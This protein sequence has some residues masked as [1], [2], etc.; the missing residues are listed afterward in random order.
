[1]NKASRNTFLK[2][3]TRILLPGVLFLGACNN[4]PEEIRALTGGARRQDDKA[5]DVTIIYSKEGKTQ[6]RIF[7]HDF[8]RNEYLKPTYID[9]NNGLKVEF[10]NDSGEVEN[11]LTADSSRFYDGLQN[12]IVWD[13]VKIVSKKGTMQTP[14]LIWNNS[15]ERF[16]TEKEVVINT[17]TE[18]LHGTGMEANR[19]FTWYR[20]IK[21]QGAV[22]VNKGEALK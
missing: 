19:D 22:Q 11:V 18:T 5:E 3:F 1:M 12:A 2:A 4:D 6:I 9:M 16:F 17:P 21:P 10:F 15:I 20:I 7:A 13:S 8:A 14:E